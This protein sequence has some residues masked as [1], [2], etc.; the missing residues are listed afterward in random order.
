MKKKTNI[1]WVAKKDFKGISVKIESKILKPL[2]TSYRFS[3]KPW[4]IRLKN[5]L[6]MTPNDPY[7][8]NDP[9][10]QL[11]DLASLLDRC[12][13]LLDTGYGMITYLVQ[14]CY[15]LD[16]PISSSLNRMATVGL[17]VKMLNLPSDVLLDPKSEFSR[18]STD[19][20]NLENAV[21][22]KPGP[23]RRT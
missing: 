3:T 21:R 16:L 14:A 23:H 1:F 5:C 13:F 6:K 17:S 2:E 12:I 9:L 19:V 11:A 4:P 10:T 18:P 7:R 20:L 8:V 15:W 22:R